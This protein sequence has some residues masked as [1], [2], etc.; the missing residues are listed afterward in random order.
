MQAEAR[1]RDYDIF[2]FNDEAVTEEAEQRAQARIDD[3]LAD[4]GVM[5]EAKN[6]ARVHLWYEDHFG[7]PYPQLASARDGIDRFL[8]LA[9]CVGI[10][11]RNSS[12]EVY[13]PNG[14]PVLYDGLLQ[15]NPLT[16]H[17]S[18]FERK[19]RSYMDRWPWLRS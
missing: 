16:A 18:L 7:F 8:V 4:L 15:P 12:F 13:A 2:C 5:V 10:R 3:V 14:L 19:A 9:T 17:G 11:P 1:I 6:Q